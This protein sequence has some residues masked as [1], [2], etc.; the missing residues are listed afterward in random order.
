MS[1][2]GK[3]LKLAVPYITAE[4]NKPFLI[5]MANGSL[6]IEKFKYYLKVDYA[7]LFDFSQI[8]ALGVYKTEDLE[9][10]N[11]LV[12][13]LDNNMREIDLN[14]TYVKKFG[15]S[16]SEMNAQKM[17]P[18]KYSYTRH[19]LSTA[20]KGNLGELLAVLLPCMVGYAEVAK[21]LMKVN[22]IQPNNPYKD[23]FDFYTSSDYVD[24]GTQS[25]EFIDKLVKDYTNFQ[26]GQLLESYLRSYYFE[27]MC[28]D[29]Y[30]AKED[31]QIK[32]IR[33]SDTK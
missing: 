28:W 32:D 2:S 27:V 16:T 5:E 3:L 1:F 25:L 15:I 26:R 24:Q 8:L 23:W 14:S 20:Q 12:R 7:Y 10:M 31:W 33:Y 18:I 11:F 29:A 22:K 17:G 13:L 9:A 19:E 6:P 30:Y 21:G 4:I